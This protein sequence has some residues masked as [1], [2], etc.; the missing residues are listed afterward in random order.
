MRNDTFDNAT[1]KLPP[2]P[3]MC[4]PTA[5]LREAAHA[6]AQGIELT[7]ESPGVDIDAIHY[8]LGAVKI[9]EAA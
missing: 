7:A 1:V 6:H 3:D 8:R 2:P 9:K 4:S 5:R